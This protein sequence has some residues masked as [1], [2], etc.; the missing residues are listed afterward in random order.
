MPYTDINL[1]P[2]GKEMTF[3]QFV[4]NEMREEGS[5]L[6]SSWYEDCSEWRVARARLLNSDPYSYS[7]VNSK[8]ERD[9]WT[10]NVHR[11]FLALFPIARISRGPDNFL[12]K[13]R[14][15]EAWELLH[16]YWKLQQ[17]RKDEIRAE[18]AERK[19]QEQ[20]AAWWP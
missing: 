7:S 11:G 15:R 5:F 17:I 12:I 4:L 3:A 6:Y 2:A 18:K 8:T 20:D 13:V 16:A 9:D 14:G 1:L 19:R 10:F